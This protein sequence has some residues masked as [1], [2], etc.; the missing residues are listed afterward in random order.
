VPRAKHR[1]FRGKHHG[2]YG[3]L[4]VGLG[5]CRL[6]RAQHGFGQAVALFRPGQ[7]EDAH[8]AGT[9]ALELAG[10][11]RGGREAASRRFRRRHP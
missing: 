8:G 3:V 11:T 1:A 2:A 4:A 10:L 5:N 7:R 9:F 6:Q